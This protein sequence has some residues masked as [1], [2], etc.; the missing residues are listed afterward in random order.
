MPPEA[1]QPSPACSLPTCP[2]FD[3]LID[4]LMEISRLDAGESVRPR[5][6]RSIWPPWS[7][8]SCTAPRGWEAAGRRD[9][10][11]GPT[12]GTDRRRV[13]QIL[14]NLVGNAVEHGG[15]RA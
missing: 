5:R 13:E 2:A 3:G 14:A 6:E 8:A 1:A 9:R 15:G 7:R 12:V 11:A 4:D 10:G